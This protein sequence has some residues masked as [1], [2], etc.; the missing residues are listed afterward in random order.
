[1]GNRICKACSF[2][3]IGGEEVRSCCGLLTRTRSVH[4]FYSDFNFLLSQ[5]S[6]QRT[7][8][9]RKRDERRSKEERKT[10]L[11]DAAMSELRG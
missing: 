3:V 10:A 6:Q 5:V 4:A 8:R 1:M 2:K 9:E 7:K 11:F